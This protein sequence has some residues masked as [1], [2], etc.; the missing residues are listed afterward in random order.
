MKQS[1][2]FEFIFVCPQSMTNKELEHQNEINSLVS[3]YNLRL[4]ETQRMLQAAMHRCISDEMGLVV[5]L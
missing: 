2:D 1:V 5:P 3:T 4:A